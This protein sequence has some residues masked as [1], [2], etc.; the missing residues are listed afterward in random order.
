MCLEFV[1]S[2]ASHRSI[3]LCVVLVG[4]IA[5]I[6]LRIYRGCSLHG[7]ALIVNGVGIN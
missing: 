7:L 2:I 4:K 6:G 5:S 1:C 3:A